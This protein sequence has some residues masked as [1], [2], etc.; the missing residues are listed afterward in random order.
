MRFNKTGVCDTKLTP[1]K[2]AFYEYK[3]NNVDFLSHNLYIV[4][5]IVGQE[6]WKAA[7]YIFNYRWCCARK[8]KIHSATIACTGKKLSVHA[9]DPNFTDCMNPMLTT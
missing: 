8:E 7:S 1:V 3:S 4:H 6:S 9:T 2:H 5:P